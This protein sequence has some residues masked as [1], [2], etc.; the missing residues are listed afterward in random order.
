MEDPNRMPFGFIP[1]TTGQIFYMS[2]YCYCTVNLKPFVPGHIL[3]LSRRPVLSVDQLMDVESANLMQTVARAM[4][5]IGIVSNGFIVHK[6]VRLDAELG[7]KEDTDLTMH[8]G[9]TNIRFGNVH[10]RIVRGVKSLVADIT[11]E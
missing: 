2:T 10:L 3:V 4:R 5:I 7:S 9:G 1:L 6:S 8:M 11:K